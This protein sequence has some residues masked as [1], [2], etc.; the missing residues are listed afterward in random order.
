M[1]LYIYTLVN[2]FKWETVYVF[3]YT[4]FFSIK[5]SKNSDYLLRVGRDEGKV[6]I[7]YFLLTIFLTICVYSFFIKEYFNNF[8]TG[9]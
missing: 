6:K 3:L 7:F 5:I 1:Q 9:L 2:F 8:K 4:E